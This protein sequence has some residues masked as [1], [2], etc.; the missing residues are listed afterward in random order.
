MELTSLDMPSKSIYGYLPLLRVEDVPQIRLLTLVKGKGDDE[1]EVSLKTAA[2]TEEATPTFE[3]LSYAWGARGAALDVI[4]RAETGET[5]SE[6]FYLEVTENLASALWH[7][8]LADRDRV[9]WVDKMC[10]DQSNTQERS[11]QVAN[12]AN[13]YRLASRVVV[14]LGLESDSSTLAMDKLGELSSS[15]TVDWRTFALTPG[16]AAESH[17]ADTMVSLPFTEEELCAIESLFSRSW[18]VRLW[19]IQ[20]VKLAQEAVVVCGHASLPWKA[21]MTSLFCLQAKRTTRDLVVGGPGKRWLFQTYIT[22]HNPQVQTQLTNLFHIASVFHC[23]DDRDRVYALPPLAG[24]P[25][26]D[27]NVIPD[28]KATVMEVYRNFVLNYIEFYRELDII[29]TLSSAR[30][31]CSWVPSFNVRATTT[32]MTSVM[33]SGNLVA[34]WDYFGSSILRVKGVYCDTIQDVNLI[35]LDKTEF[36]AIQLEISRLVSLVTRSEAYMTGCSAILA[37][38]VTLACHRDFVFDPPSPT[39]WSTGQLEAFMLALLQYSPEQ[40]DEVL[41]VLLPFASHIYNNCH[42]RALATTK[43]GCFALVPGDTKPGDVLCC[44]LGLRNMAVLRPAQDS[45]AEAHYKVVGSCF[46]HGLSSGEALFGPFTD[47]WQPAVVFSEVE[48]HYQWMYRNSET[49]EER[50]EDPRLEPLHY[51][52]VRVAGD[53]WSKVVIDYDQLD[54]K[55]VDFF[56]V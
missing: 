19:V 47:S 34:D 3:A 31:D 46:V 38:A 39:D 16:D 27:L 8:R 54:G 45:A 30:S 35:H 6:A 29:V 50:T 41:D 13:V 48:E 4:A 26:A 1:L 17:W 43:D 55:V 11:S 49:G 18:F 7:L 32:Y 37:V 40:G 52:S 20:E 23:T 25:L 12:M 33:A 36:E 24:A 28:Y 9:L 5:K 51:E 2:L 44:L 53:A 22:L 56:L 14:W 42:G 15:V 21:L 10:I